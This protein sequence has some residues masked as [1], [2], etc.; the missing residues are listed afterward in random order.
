MAILDQHGNPIRPADIAEPQ[1]ARIALL[2]HQFIE[3]HLDG[4]T[5]ARAARI[6][7]QAD[8]GDL[9]AQHSLF[10]DMLDRDAHLRCEYEKRQGALLGLDWSIEAPRDA[11]AAE[12]KTAAWVEEILRDVVDD[13]EDVLLALQEA[14]GH[15]FAA[16]EL[17]WIYQGGER[18]PRFH[19]RPQ[20]WFRM[21][22]DR[23][24]LRVQDGSADGAEP[25]PMGWILHKARKPKTGYDAR[26]GLFRPCLWPFLYKAYSAGDFSELLEVYGLP[27]ILGKYMPGATAD[28]KSSLMRAVASLGREAR[29][30]MPDGMQV[31]LL[32]VTGGGEKSLHLEMVAWAEAAQ[33][34]AVLGQVLSADAKATGLGSGVADLHQLVREDIRA[35]DARQVAATLTRDLVYPLVALNRGGV[36]GLRRCPRWRFDL[37]EA[38]DVAAYADAL[39]KLVAV[40]M[41][42][43][44]AWAH[45][46]LRI[47]EPDG[48]EEVLAVAAPAA[49]PTS[50]PGK[51]DMPPVGKA[52]LKAAGPDGGS[53]V[54]FPDQA[55]L[56]A[57]L[58]ALPA[59]VLDQAMQ[60]ALA[61]VFDALDGVDSW[62]AAYTALGQLYPRMDAREL[63]QR[64]A[65]CLFA[66]EAFGRA[67]GAES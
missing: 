31:E 13:L 23:R 35:A 67:T 45:E 11:S 34:K 30:I 8:E 17:E 66:A 52:A 4:I 60:R 37:G 62:E 6:L 33:S 50:Q 61:P 41:Q 9:A 12:K 15:G 46:R 3:S 16:V 43:P 44:R 55:A 24:C 54:N 28:E 51:S 64:L 58:D 14:P 7:R 5:P 29:A 65:Q 56:D 47:P 22:Q 57:A 39:P 48:T 25:I 40:G 26:S 32:K 20:A 27:M 38:E 18:L 42:I 49:A 53:G 36:D 19:P 1:T 21:S 63:E 2:Q 10:D 59:G